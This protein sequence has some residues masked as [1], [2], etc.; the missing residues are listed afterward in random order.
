MMNVAK[1][2]KAFSTLTLGGHKDSIYHQLRSQSRNRQGTKG[3]KRY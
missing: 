3:I 2:S 1:K